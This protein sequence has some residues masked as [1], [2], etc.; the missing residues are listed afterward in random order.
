VPNYQVFLKFQN[1]IDVQ[2]DDFSMYTQNGVTICEFY[3]NVEYTEDSKK[4]VFFPKVETH[5]FTRAKKI[6]SLS[7]PSPEY[8][9]VKEV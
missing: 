3:N 4:G 7:I 8:I 5:K 6:L 2:A 1:S 9:I